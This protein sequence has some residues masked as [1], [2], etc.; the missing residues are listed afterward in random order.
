MDETNM[1]T[2]LHRAQCFIDPRILSVA[3]SNSCSFTTIWRKRPLML[4]KYNK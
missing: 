4:K 3:V 2:Q 1:D